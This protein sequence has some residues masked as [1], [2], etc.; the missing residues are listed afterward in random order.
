MAYYYNEPSRTFNEFLLIPGYTS[1]DCVPANVS[2]TPT[3][4]GFKTGEEPAP[5]L[6]IP[7]L[8]L[9]PR[10]AVCPSFTAPSPSRTRPPWSPG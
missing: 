3:L 2:L 1:E 4:E 7:W 6:T 5:A 10:K 9:W 8:S